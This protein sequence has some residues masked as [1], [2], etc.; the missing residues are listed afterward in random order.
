MT[1][2][3]RMSLS[4]LAAADAVDI[5]DEEDIE[6]DIQDAEEDSFVSSYVA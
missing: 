3:G 4:L 5:W 2:L 1:R 6:K